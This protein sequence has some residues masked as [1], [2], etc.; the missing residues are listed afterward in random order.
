VLA[1]CAQ[2]AAILAKLV[3][4]KFD[5]LA[6]PLPAKR[7]LISPAKQAVRV[8]LPFTEDVMNKAWQRLRN[9]KAIKDAR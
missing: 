6:L 5:P 1:H 8:A 9:S 7:G 4:L 2:E 3:E